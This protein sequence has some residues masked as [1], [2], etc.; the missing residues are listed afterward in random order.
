L[1]VISITG[2]GLIAAITLLGFAGGLRINTT[3]SAPVGLWRIERLDREV[4]IGDLVFV[5][6]PDRQEFRLAVERNYLPHGLCLGGFAPLIKTVAALAGQYIDISGVV[7]IDGVALQH[8]DLRAAD[9][10]GRPLPRYPGG[11]VP[12]GELFLHSDFGGSYDSRYFGPVPAS[13]VLGLA[14]PL[15]TF[16]P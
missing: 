10:A 6:P 5:C 15:L 8:S 3:P 9:A 12:P 7:T 1:V 16:V 2:A 14:R 13:G 11:R 4:Q